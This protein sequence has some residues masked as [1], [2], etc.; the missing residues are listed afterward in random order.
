MA[1]K[2]PTRIIATREDADRTLQ[3][4]GALQ[5]HVAQAEKHA[6]DG[7]D[8]IRELLVQETKPHREEL[9]QQEAALEAWAKEDSKVW[10][11][12]SLELNWGSVG[13]HLGKPAI[14]L[15][16]AVE[17]VIEKLRGKKMA[18]CIRV[19]EEVD[20]EALANYDDDMIAAV[21]CARTKPKDKFWYK[22]KAEEV[23]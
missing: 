19:V 20:K 15:K 8:Q 13:Y 17:N 7:I 21:G 18:T 9:A 23:K 6:S 10:D 22:C 14:K 5:R 1:K 2:Q 16:L 3:R 11:K 4:I 12:K